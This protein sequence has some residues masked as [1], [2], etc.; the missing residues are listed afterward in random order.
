MC[1]SV[2]ARVELA[3]KSMYES[4]ACR[5]FYRTRSGSYNETRDPT[6]GAEVVGT[7][8]QQLGF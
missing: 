3:Q 4:A 8:L 6:S 5:S 7:L 2:Q 1:V